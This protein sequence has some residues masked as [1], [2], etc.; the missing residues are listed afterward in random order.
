MCP[1]YAYT[2]TCGHTHTVF[3][4]WCTPAQITQ[5]R[6][7]RRAATATI[8]ASLSVEEE[9]QECEMGAGVGCSVAD[10]GKRAAVA[11]AK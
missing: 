11:G 10:T 2:F 6:C 9:C 5:R 1:Y 7:D 3:A 4:D 8:S